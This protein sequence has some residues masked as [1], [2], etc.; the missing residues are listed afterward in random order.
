MFNAYG[1]TRYFGARA[2]LDGVTLSIGAGE[3]VGLVGRNGCGKSTLLRILAGEER[4]DSGG[5]GGVRRGL[6]VGY[7]PQLPDFAPDQTVIQAATSGLPS[8]VSEWQVR[9]ALAGLGIGRSMLDQRAGTLSGGEKTR[10]MLARLLV[11]RHDLLLL[12]EPTNHLDIPMLCRLEET[13]RD[14]RGA[15][16]VASHDRRFLDGTVTRILELEEGHLTGYAGNYAAYAEAKRRA[17]MQQEADYQLQQ[18]QV[19]ALQE[20]VTRQMGWAAQTADGPKRG[21]DQRGRIGAKIAKRAHAAERQIERILD[22]T[23]IERAEGGASGRDPAEKRRDMAHVTAQFQVRRRSGQITC[24][25]RGLC[26]VYGGRTLFRDLDLTL[27]YGERIGIVGANGAGKTTLLRLLLGTEPATGG[28]V[29]TGARVDPL[30][31]TQ[32]QEH[33]KPGLTVLETIEAGSGLSHTE[34]RTLLACFLFRETEVFKR[35]GDLSA[36]ERV[37]LAVAGAVVSGANLLVLDEP[38]NH[39]DIDTRERLEDAIAAYE[40][41][42]LVVSHDRYLLNRLADRLLIIANG[43]VE[44]FPGPYRDWEAQHD[45]E[46]PQ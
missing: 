13:L 17:L 10:L 4:P 3:R 31:L 21:R 5:I 15:Y 26:K 43:A 45:S 11:G 37:R 38:A 19:R 7:L 16:L 35:V 32:E 39:L 29:R 18:K 42:L 36:G 9:K 40:G 27:H 2:L 14:Y 23:G 20:F 12:D 6:A 41:T 24:E 44:D 8:D 34:A 30:F 1:I 22:P 25:A 33:L 46:Q 28:E